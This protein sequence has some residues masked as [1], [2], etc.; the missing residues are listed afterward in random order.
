M[1][2]IAYRT[3]CICMNGPP[4]ERSLLVMIQ[5]NFSIQQN[6]TYHDF[7]NCLT[8][9]KMNLAKAETWGQFRITTRSTKSGW[10]AAN[11]QVTAPPQS[12][13]TSVHFWWPEKDNV[14]TE[15]GRVKL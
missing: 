13:P 7:R 2:K 8:L 10:F 11:A 14:F 1:N 3:V 15:W 9:L 4:N 12:C 6:D 5:M